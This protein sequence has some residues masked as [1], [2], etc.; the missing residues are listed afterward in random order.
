[1]K[2]AILIL[3]MVSW[4]NVGFAEAKEAF[5]PD[6]LVMWKKYKSNNKPNQK[7]LDNA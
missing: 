5:S 4:C 7:Y 1:M 3:V 6:E 2:K